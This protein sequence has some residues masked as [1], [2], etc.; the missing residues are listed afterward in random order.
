MPDPRPEARR[1]IVISDLHIGGKAPAMMSSGDRLARF[2]RGLPAQRLVDES[3]ELVIA[4]DFIDFLAEEPYASWTAQPDEGV[5]KLRRVM[6]DEQFSPVFSALAWFVGEGHALTVLVGNHDVELALPAAQAALLERLQAT[7]H[8][9]KFVDDGRAYRIG[10]MLIEHGNRYDGANENDWTNLRI[11]AST[12]SRG[13]ASPVELRVSAGSWMVEKVVAPLKERYPFIDLLQPQGELLAL[14]LA[15]F[16]PGFVFDLKRISRSL[17]AQRLEAS[18]AKGQQPGHTYA[19]SAY[20]PAAPTDPELLAAFGEAYTALRES[21]KKEVSVA[22]VLLAAWRN[23]KD[24]LRDRLQSGAEIPLKQLEQI[25]VAMKKLLLADKDNHW[26][27]DTA[28]YGAAAQRLLDTES[29]KTELVVMG[30]THLARHHGPPGRA[31]Y[32]NSGTWADVIR[33]PA[34]V[35]EPGAHAQLTLFLQ[36]LLSGGLRDSPA[37]YA[38]VRIEHSGRVSKARLASAAR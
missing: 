22:D 5:S 19:A 26:G 8:Q 24:G 28:Q 23:R 11:I 34:A 15:A 25:R 6:K 33:V 38:D 12:Q 2:I 37:T 14:L 35:L 21:P 9:V 18:N 4:G 20:A 27:G 32:I 7:P 3:L 36:Q 29:A 1:V 30:H 31:N 10:R 17:H 16:E 13:E